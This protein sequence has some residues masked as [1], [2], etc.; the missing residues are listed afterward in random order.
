MKSEDTSMPKEPRPLQYFLDAA[1]VS[2]VTLAADNKM[3]TCDCAAFKKNSTCKHLTWVNTRVDDKG[4]YPI[5][6]SKR[7]SKDE[8]DAAFGKGG[9]HY[10][11]FM[12]KYGRVEVLN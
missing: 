11:S 6:V 2:T 4:I 3:L 12:L 1:G 7:A 5:Q 10:R 9:E 8:M